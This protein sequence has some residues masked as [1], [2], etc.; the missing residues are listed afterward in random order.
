MKKIL[1]ISIVL[2]ICMFCSVPVSAG[3]WGLPPNRVVDEAG[4]LT[5]HEGRD[6]TKKLEEISGNQNCDV[7]IVTVDSLGRKT[8]T[9]YADD[10]FDDNDYGIGDDNDGILFLIGMDERDWAISTCGEFGISAF[11]DAGQAYIMDDVKPFLSADDFNGAF[12]MFAERCDEFLTQANTGTPYDEDNLPK[13]EKEPIDWIL[14]VVI[15][16]GI[17]GILSFIILGIV[18]MPLKSVRSQPKA[19]SYLRENSMVVRAKTES[20]LYS[21]V[22]KTARQN[23]SSGGGSST[24]TS[25]SG[26]SHGGSSGKF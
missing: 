25:S 1:S 12:T 18:K 8:S 22:S 3:D 19:D 6:L 9:E 23:N 15:S 5:H 24:H 17:G 14:M 13:R 4:L 10:F 2:M 26:R 11:T 7:V 20:Y 21:R 16:F